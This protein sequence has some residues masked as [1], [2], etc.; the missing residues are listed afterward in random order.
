MRT[1][2][3][4]CTLALVG[5]FFAGC[6]SGGTSHEEEV[7]IDTVDELATAYSDCGYDYAST[8]ADILSA[9]YDCQ[10]VVGIRDEAELY[11]VC[12]PALDTW[13]CADFDNGLIPSSC[14]SQ[15][16]F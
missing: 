12:F 1:I 10:G 8:R 2:C 4:V 6:D 11:N 7:C 14:Q 15:I 13:D 3:V 16:L 5:V 9:M